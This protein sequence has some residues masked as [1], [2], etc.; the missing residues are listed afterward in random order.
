MRVPR[1]DL[2][3]QPRDGL[4]VSQQRFGFNDRCD[5]VSSIARQ[6]FVSDAAPAKDHECQLS[7]EIRLYPHEEFIQDAFGRLF[8]NLGGIA[9]RDYCG[10]IRRFVRERLRQPRDGVD[11][12]L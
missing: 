9:H 3:G 1:R 2:H 8:G 4:T 6:L 5:V 12:Q 10:G 11:L 7:R